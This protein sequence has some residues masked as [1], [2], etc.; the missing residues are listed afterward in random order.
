MAAARRQDSLMSFNR[1]AKN[2]LWNLTGQTA[3]LVIALVAVP[4][5][6][7]ALGMDRYGF[8]SLAW[9]LVG[10]AGL[11]DLGVSRA[12]TRLVAQR[13]AQH[14]AEG[15]RRVG[16]VAT[17]FMLALGLL[18]GALLG[19]FAASVVDGWLKVS[20]TLR[21]EA[22]NAIWLLAVSMPIVLLTSA[23][24]GY[25]EAHQSFK[26]LN[27]V[28]VVMGVFTFVGPL[29]AAWISP[30]LEVTVGAVVVMRLI[31]ASAHASLAARLC[32]YKYRFSLPDRD[33][34]RHLFALGGWMS[35]SNVIGPI[36]SYMDRF[37]LGGLVAMQLV[38][39]YATP[40]DLIMRTMVLPYAVMGALFPMLAG[41]AGNT[42][43]IS[44][45]YNAS[46]RML[47]VSMFPVAFVAITLGGPF[48]QAWLGPNFAQHGSIVLQLLAVGVLANSLAQ[49]PANL[50]QGLGQPKWMAIAHLAELP[51][52]LASIWYFTHRFGIAGTA[53]CWAL[54]TVVDCI[55]LFTLVRHKLSVSGIRTGSAVIC[56]GLA[57][58]LC[59]TGYLADTVAKSWAV[60]VGGLLLF[61]AFAWWYVLTRMERNTV[62]RY[63]MRLTGKA[64]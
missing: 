35:V 43:R 57:T 54:R 25:I 12:M 23:Y 64:T 58:A 14:D 39:Y 13:L 27:L 46:I 42:Q 8:L 18:S 36:M 6:I 34:T 20:A 16:S 4:P 21:D 55:I 33:T 50:I 9:A 45:T 41:L 49:A 15:A 60:S 40:Y 56:L 51:F 10:Y 38:A 37:I 22:I 52:F 53:F 26:A 1:F 62:L 2:A 24:R 32:G 44:E 7:R 29:C 48:L 11:F 59:V 19:G 47:F 17:T 28:R 63:A 31:A 30:R 61:G 3:P 5:L